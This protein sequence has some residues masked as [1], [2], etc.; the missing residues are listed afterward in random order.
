MAPPDVGPH[1]DD[2]VGGCPPPRDPLYSIVVDVWVLLDPCNNLTVRIYNLS[3]I[4][5]R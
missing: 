3:I 5:I 2:H 4:K 1:S